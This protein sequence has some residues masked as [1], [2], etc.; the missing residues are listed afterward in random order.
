MLAVSEHINDHNLSY[1]TVN[2]PH[3][4][5]DDSLTHIDQSNHWVCKEKQ[6]ITSI[7]IGTLRD[8]RVNYYKYLSKDNSLNNEDKHLY[9]VISQAI[10]VILNANVRKS[11][12]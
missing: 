12:P 10:K 9:N 7:L 1:E 11:T 5:K 8:L 2:C 6:G 4:I 3:E